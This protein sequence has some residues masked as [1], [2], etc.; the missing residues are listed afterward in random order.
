MVGALDLINEHGIALSFNQLGF[1]RA[2]PTEPVFITMCRIAEHC[3]TFAEAEAEILTCPSGMPFLLTLSSASEQRAAVFER[4]R[5]EIVR[6][7][8]ADGWVAACNLAQGADRGETVLDQ[9]MASVT[10]KNAKELIAVLGDA[11][12][13]MDS[14][15]YSVIFDHTGNRLLLAPA[16][17]LPRRPPFRIRSCFLAE[18]A[19]WGSSVI[20]RFPRVR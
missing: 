15:I 7:D 8:L 13:L 11:R 17:R 5:S 2:V 14:N 1:G 20:C 6:R 16:L 12:V 9:Q 18:I 10:P 19:A 3:R 4:Q